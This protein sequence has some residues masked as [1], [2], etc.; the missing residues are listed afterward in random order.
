MLLKI[1]IVNL[2]PNV[3][4]YLSQSYEFLTGVV[5]FYSKGNELNVI[6]MVHIV[7]TQMKM[8]IVYLTSGSSNLGYLWMIS[9]PNHF[10][11][12]VH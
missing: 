1:N 6:Q 9:C 4:E 8:C 7:H 2:C 3:N 12:R 5:S 10:L 11:L